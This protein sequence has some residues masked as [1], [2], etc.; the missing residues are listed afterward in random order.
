MNDKKLIEEIIEAAYESVEQLKKVAKRKLDDKEMD[1]EKIK[2]AAS[3]YKLAIN[4]AFEILKIIKEH[5]EMLNDESDTEKTK[6]KS[7]RRFDGV[8]SLKQ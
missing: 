4:D 1:P 3:Y 7:T 6:E 2:Q 8:E 5:K